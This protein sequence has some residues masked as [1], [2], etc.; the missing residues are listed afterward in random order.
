MP[1]PIAFIWKEVADPDEGTG[2]LSLAMVP[3]ARYRNI[4]KRQFGAPGS[5]HVLEPIQERSM[6]SHSQY[7]AALKDSFDNLPEN[8]AARWPTPQH[9]RKWLLIEAGYFD[10]KEMHFPN[11]EKALDAANYIRGLDEYARIHP[12]GYTL[13]IRRAKSQ[14]LS[15]M[16]KREFEESKRAVLD[17][18]ER[19]TGVPRGQAMREAGRSA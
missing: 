12:H 18:A 19:F 17:L 2:E 3:A 13:L 9:F 6:A 16:G 8:V 15:A 14:S 10:E 5:E 1:Q 11:A 7:F 4:A